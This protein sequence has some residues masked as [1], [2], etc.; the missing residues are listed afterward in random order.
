ME[1]SLEMENRF[2]GF[3]LTMDVYMCYMYICVLHGEACLRRCRSV[4]L[5]FKKKKSQLFLHFM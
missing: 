1:T 5:L 4:H 3:F 2:S